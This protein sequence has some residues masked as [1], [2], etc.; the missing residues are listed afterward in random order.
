MI[1]YRCPNC[2]AVTTIARTVSW[3]SADVTL[4][5]RCRSAV[6]TLVSDSSVTDCGDFILR[7]VPSWD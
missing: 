7:V 3:A 4:C 6:M 1:T 5:R 2:S